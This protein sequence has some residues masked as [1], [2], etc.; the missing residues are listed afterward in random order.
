MQRLFKK[1]TFSAFAAFGLKL[2]S[3]LDGG[4][5]TCQPAQRLASINVGEIYLR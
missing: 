4:V 5:L 1:A 3:R 2:C